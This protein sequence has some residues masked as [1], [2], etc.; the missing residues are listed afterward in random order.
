MLQKWAL[1]ALEALP[2]HSDEI[3]S[4]VR[5]FSAAVAAASDSSS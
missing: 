3:L 1:Q 4:T 2:Q 5:D